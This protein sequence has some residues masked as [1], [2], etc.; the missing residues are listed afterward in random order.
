MSVP[1]SKGLILL[2]GVVAVL[3][4]SLL[5]MSTG[6][7]PTSLLHGGHTGQATP[8]VFAADQETAPRATASLSASCLPSSRPQN[9]ALELQ[10]MLFRARQHAEQQHAEE[11]LAEFRNIATLDPAVPSLYLNISMALMQLK[12]PEEARSAIDAQLATSDCLTKLQPSDFAAYCHSEMSSQSTESCRRQTLDVRRTAHMQAALVE[13]ELGRA[14][15]TMAP[16]GVASAAPQQE[17]PLPPLMPA[18][19]PAHQADQS[20]ASGTGTD[21]ALGAYSK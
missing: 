14:P 2:G 7:L 3:A 11:A 12:R 21:A 20:L 16:S 5:A 4:V 8:E 19:H 17:S 1:A 6:L 9:S 15:E 18:K 13:M 10:Q